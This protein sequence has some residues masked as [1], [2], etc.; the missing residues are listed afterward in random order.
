VVLIHICGVVDEVSINQSGVHKIP[1][2]ISK[3]GFMTVTTD[4]V[5][6]RPVID[7]HAAGLKVGEVAINELRGGAKT[8][9]AVHAAVK[10]GLAIGFPNCC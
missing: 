4:Y 6:P 9:E 5:G 2:K 7:L 8:E 3:P 10:S 1:K